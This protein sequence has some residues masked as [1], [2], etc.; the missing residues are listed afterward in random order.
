MIVTDVSYL[1]KWKL[2]SSVRLC[3]PKDYTVHGILQARILEWVPVPFSRG[4]S[5][6]RS[7]ALQAPGSSWAT[8]EAYF[9]LKIYL[10]II[11]ILNKEN[12]D[13][14]IRI[15]ILL[16]HRLL[17]WDKLWSLW[18]GVRGG[19]GREAHTH[20]NTYCHRECPQA[21]TFFFFYFFLKLFGRISWLV[22]S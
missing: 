5:Q 1:A 2:L 12:W 7:P 19:P 11:T 6:P 16:P 3:D 13:P 10:I 20:Y 15:M 14:T 9:I 4:S 18:M 17:W 22:G 21:W 8:R